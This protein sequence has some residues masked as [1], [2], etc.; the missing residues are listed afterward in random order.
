MVVFRIF[1]LII[2]LNLVYII[3]TYSQNYIKI[4][5]S[6]FGLSK[7]NND[8][9][10]YTLFIPVTD[11]SCLKCFVELCDYIKKAYQYKYSITAIYFTNREYLTHWRKFEA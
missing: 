8:T 1:I 11:K 9:S 7:Q 5:D 3:P 6:L 10:S 2:L 4:T